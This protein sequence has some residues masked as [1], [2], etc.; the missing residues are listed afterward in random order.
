MSTALPHLFEPFEI[1]GCRIKNRIFSTGHDT[2]MPTDGTPNKRLA[3]Y[4]EARAAGGAGL[5]IMQVAGVHETARYTSH[6]IMATTDDCIPGYRDVV[7]ACKPYGTRLFGQ[8]FHPGREIMESQDGTAPVAF[9][10]SAVPNERFHVMPKPM[11]KR[12]IH[13]IIDGYAAAALRLKKGGLDGV[14]IVASHGYLPAQFL[15]ERVNRRE[16]EYGGSFENRLRFLR[17]VCQAVRDRVGDEMVVGIRITGDEKDP[18][19]LQESESLAAIAALDGAVDFFNVIAGTSASFG[20]AVHIAPPMAIANGYVAPFAA[21]VKQKVKAAVLV[22]GRI[23]QPQDAEKI[24]ASGAADLIGMTRAMICDPDMP[25]K[26]EAGRLDDIRACIACNQACIG[27]FHLGY[28]ISCIQHPETGRE[29]TYGALKP[30]ARKKKI[31]IA[32]GGPA[33]MKAAAI[34]GARGHEVILCEASERLGGQ[35]LIAQLLPSRAEFG[36][37]VTNLAREVE[38]AGVT[39]RTRT[40]VTR[41]LVEQEK[42]DAV[43]IATGARPRLAAE[44][45]IEGVEEGS[46][47]VSAWAAIRDEANIGRSVVIAD[48][49]CDWIGLGLAEKLA[50]NGCHV[51]L[52]VDGYMAGQRIHQYVRDH[53]VG[54][55]HKL[56]VE[57]VPYARL[58]GIDGETVYFQHATSGEPIIFE[59]VDTLVTSLGHHRVAGLEEELADWQGEVHVIGDSLT[60][61]TAEEAVLE[62]LKV[63]AEI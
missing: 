2:T 53:W 22:A 3:A 24:L 16:D 5:I 1:R 56:N 52:C 51:R 19:G 59:G 31:L 34:A 38:R 35:A 27:H 18:E 26:A 39:V 14:E 36:G 9:A 50:R 63:T 23:N 55:L 37:I 49:R 48:W 8:L 17:E 6:L 62:G 57:V 45:G 60:P 28:P 11:S 4:H 10:P 61:R 29:L 40:T 44:A 58:Y 7:A 46:H 41:A 13:E 25:R 30:A 33:G 43:I 20:G 47:V 12:M 32:G 42:P 21:A 54:E 15:N